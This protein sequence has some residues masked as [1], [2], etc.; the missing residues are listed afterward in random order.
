[1]KKLILILFLVASGLNSVAQQ[2]PTLDPR[3]KILLEEKDSSSIQKNI[4]KL[5]NSTEESDMGIVVQYYNRKNEI[6]NAEKTIE[7]II[8]RFPKGEY[9]FT[10]EANKLV[11]IKDPKEKEEKL[12]DL[13]SK[14]PDQDDRYGMYYF[15]VS[16]TYANSGNIL[17]AKEYLNQMKPDNMYRA[18]AV[19]IIL[20]NMIDTNPESRMAFLEHQTGI[21]ERNA[22]T[23]NRGGLASINN[24]KILEAKL[25]REMGQN[26]KALDVISEVY[27]GA[28][29]K[30]FDLL[31]YYALIQADNGNYKEALPILENAVKS[32]KSDEKIKDYLKKA[33]AQ[34]DNELPY[35]EYLAELTNKLSDSIYNH[36]KETMVREK[37][38]SFEVMDANGKKVSFEDLKGK[39]LVIDFWA[40]WCGPCKKSFPS[41]QRALNKFRNDKDVQ[42]MFV[43]TFENGEKPLAAAMEY[44]QD[45]N[46]NFPLYMD[47]KNT[48]TGMNPM[49]SA[50]EVRGIPTKIIIGPDGFVKFKITGFFGGEDAAVEEISTMIELA[51]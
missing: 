28:E 19:Q 20:E 29:N 44:L 39:T 35:N 26:K 5:L 22:S 16:A 42:F 33:Y 27:R 9:A 45:K 23:E 40:T 25:Y 13:K 6:G 31:K 49:A 48:E 3:L 50:F 12:F 4:Q 41:M 7:K 18:Y 46:Y 36:L 24:L 37:A 17:K 8:K 43:H 10:Q 21:L 11:A 2:R 47:Y 1:M 30:N 51:Q 38:P 32:G 34:T 14:F 15:D